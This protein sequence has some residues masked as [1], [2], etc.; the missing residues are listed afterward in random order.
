M[1]E[2]KGNKGDWAEPYAFLKALG[3]GRIYGADADQNRKDNVYYDV[4][5]VVRTDL[6][7]RRDY[8]VDRENSTVVV[9]D[10]DDIV[11][12]LPMSRFRDEYQ[13]MFEKM[14]STPGRSFTIPESAAFLKS[15]GAIKIKAGSGKKADITIRIF[16]PQVGLEVEQ[17]FSIKSKLKSPATLIN[18]STHTNFEYLLTGFVQDDLVIQANE[19]L[20]AKS[21]KKYE[22]AFSLLSSNGM[23]IRFVQMMSPT[24]SDN[25]TMIGQEIPKIA[26]I[27]VKEWYWNRHSDLMDV[28]SE[29]VKKNPLAVSDGMKAQYYTKRVKDLLTAHALGLQPSKVW[30]GE[31]E[32]NGGYILVKESGEVLCYH[33]YDRSDFMEYLYRNTKMETPDTRNGFGTF[34]RKDESWFIKLNLQVRF[35]Q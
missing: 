7:Y 19:I 25:L 29:I 33:V 23:D 20:S 32:A 17:D 10:G 2:M 9:K 1:M 31:E 12:Q 11:L 3:D 16:E 8:T 26:S 28:V 27:M 35:K 24:Y 22:D 30:S 18:A 14:M 5:S 4:S 6:G 15:L 13:S 34:Y 21:K